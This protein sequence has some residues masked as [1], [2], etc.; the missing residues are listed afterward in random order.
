MNWP[1]ILSNCGSR[2]AYFIACCCACPAAPLFSPT[3]IVVV[4]DL[5]PQCHRRHRRQP[6]WPHHL[7]ARG[8]PRRRVGGFEDRIDRAYVILIAVK[9]AFDVLVHVSIDLGRLRAAPA[10]AWGRLPN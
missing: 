9:T 2:N 7:D 5:V 1:T 6:L 4:I 8:H 10:T 3:L